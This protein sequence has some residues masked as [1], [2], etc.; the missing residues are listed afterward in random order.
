MELIKN[1]T[2]VL[3]AKAKIAPKKD[4]LNL[5]PNGELYD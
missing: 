4:S 3:K 1:K 2:T 5:D